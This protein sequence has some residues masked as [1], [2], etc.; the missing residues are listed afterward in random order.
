MS[1]KEAHGS[2]LLYPVLFLLLGSALAV[3]AGE[4]TNR[5]ARIYDDVCAT[6]IS[7]EDGKAQL[8]DLLANPANLP[9]QIEAAEKIA[10]LVN[11]AT[12]QKYA[13]KRDEWEMREYQSYCREQYRFATS[14]T[15]PVLDNLDEIHRQSLPALSLSVTLS[16]MIVLSEMDGMATKPLALLETVLDAPED[17]LVPPDKVLAEDEDL[18]L[19]IEWAKGELKKLKKLAASAIITRCFARDFVLQGPDGRRRLDFDRIKASIE[20]IMEKYKDNADIQEVGE[21]HLTQLEELRARTTKTELD[22][23]IREVER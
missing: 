8:L 5:A 6:R 1:I 18:E 23:I 11:V 22:A 9:Q 17:H 3:R 10:L 4:P 13:E 19:E 16:W 14:V 20:R 12:Q 7:A 2:R 21:R 15:L